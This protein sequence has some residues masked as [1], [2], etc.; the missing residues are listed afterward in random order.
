[1][2]LKVN[3]KS[4][5]TAMDII[6]VVMMIGIF[7]FGAAMLIA[8]VKVEWLQSCKKRLKWKR[9]ERGSQIDTGGVELGTMSEVEMVHEPAEGRRQDKT[10]K[11]AVNPLMISSPSDMVAMQTE[12]R[13]RG[14]NNKNNKET[15]PMRTDKTD[16]EGR[17][18]VTTKF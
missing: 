3:V 2:I 17:R 18:S 8:S 5:Q 15:G 12:R 16:N 4:D 11:W 13:A 1:M 6:L 10:I 9:S 7:V 14:T